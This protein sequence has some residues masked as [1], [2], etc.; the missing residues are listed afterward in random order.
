MRA[1]SATFVMCQ[2][3]LLLLNV[4]TIEAG[5]L[6]GKVTE[7]EKERT[8][9]YRDVSA[10]AVSQQEPIISNIKIYEFDALEAYED[11]EIK[12]NLYAGGPQGV[13]S[14]GEFIFLGQRDGVVLGKVESGLTRIDDPGDHSIVLITDFITTEPYGTLYEV[15]ALPEE[16]R[17]YVYDGEV[18]VTST[19]PRF[20]DTIYVHAGEWVRARKGQ[21]ISPKKRFMIATG[22]GSGSSACI[23][24][25]CKITDDPRIPLEPVVT[26]QVLIPP[27]PNPPSR[28]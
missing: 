15:Y 14:S 8:F 2:G 4:A 3:L 11:S 18:A 10:H 9:I 23:Y 12:F 21:T 5:D 19:D 20:T 13:V 6:V 16:S 22:P 24:S 27:N 25:N 17:V 1:I 26:P 7:F 28:R